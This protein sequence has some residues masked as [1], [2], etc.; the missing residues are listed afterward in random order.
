MLPQNRRDFLRTSALAGIG[1]G[2]LGPTAVARTYLPPARVLS[3]AA[4]GGLALTAAVDDA[5]RLAGARPGASETLRMGVR[6]DLDGETPGNVALT[7]GGLLQ[8]A[9]GAVAG[10]LTR[11]RDGR[12]HEDPEDAGRRLGFALGWFAFRGARGAFGPLYADLPAGERDARGVYV[13]AAVLRGR[14][15]RSVDDVG[16]VDP[17]EVGEL[18]ALMGARSLVRF[19][20]LNPDY[21][22]I[23]GWVDRHAAWRERQ[24]AYLADLA[25][26]YGA[27]DAGELARHVRGPA[28]YGA[29]DPFVAAARGVAAGESPDLTGI[30]AAPPTTVYGRAVSNALANLDAADRLLA[31]DLAPAAFVDAVR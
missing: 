14:S 16:A 8:T 12:L 19:H 24:S 3:P 17:A 7:A 31:G 15:G 23:P 10:L 5:L 29:S 13:D 18:L 20:T 22:D 30:A 11:W 4:P 1:L 28:A 2:V 27:P 21:D 6:R 9:P 26:A 25:R